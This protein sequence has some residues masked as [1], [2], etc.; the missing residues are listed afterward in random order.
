[1]HPGQELVEGFRAD[2]HHHRKAD[3]RTHGEPAAYGDRDLKGLIFA[4]P[5][6]PGPV[7]CRCYRQHMVDR[8]V[9]H[10]GG[11]PGEGTV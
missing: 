9:S 11:Q 2:G 6:V 8:P 4:D 5:I 1:M 3:R 7:R 10:A